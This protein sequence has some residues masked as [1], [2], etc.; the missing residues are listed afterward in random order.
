MTLLTVAKINCLFNSKKGENKEPQS[1][2]YSSSSDTRNVH[3]KGKISKMK[4]GMPL[5]L[6]KHVMLCKRQMLALRH[7]IH[8]NL[9]KS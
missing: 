3:T 2:G 9:M 7:W 6:L 1:L 8:Q 5:K 4:L